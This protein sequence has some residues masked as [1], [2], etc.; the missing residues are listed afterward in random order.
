MCVMQLLMDSNRCRSLY[1]TEITLHWPVSR[2]SG[3]CFISRLT[4]A[5]MR[6]VTACQMKVVVMDIALAWQPNALIM[7]H[8][9]SSDFWIIQGF[10]EWMLSVLTFKKMSLSV[11]WGIPRWNSKLPV[12]ASVS[13]VSS[14]NARLFL[15]HKKSLQLLFMALESGYSEDKSFT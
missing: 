9:R 5:V 13:S 11:S 3:S 6:M 12:R 4:P 2:R 8:S 15:D 7:T 10:A 1:L 14:W